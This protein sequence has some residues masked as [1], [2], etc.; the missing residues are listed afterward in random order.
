MLAESLK[1]GSL[2]M[3]MALSLVNVSHKQMSFKEDMMKRKLLA[4][5]T[6]IMMV[7][8]F[9]VMVLGDQFAPVIV[10]TP[11]S[12]EITPIL[13][14]QGGFVDLT[15]E[16]ILGPGNFTFVH[17][18]WM[19]A[20]ELAGPSVGDTAGDRFVS[21]ARFSADNLAIGTKVTVTYFIVVS[22]GTEVNEPYF[23][24]DGDAYIEIIEDRTVII[25]VE[26]KAAPAVAAAILKFNGVDARFGNGRSGGNFI[27]DVAHFMGPGTEFAG[28]PK[29][30]LVE[31]KEVSNPAYWEAVLDFLNA[32]PAM[33]VVLEM[34]EM[35]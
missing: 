21:T 32:H 24:A 4:L 27:A 1:C 33:K 15:A 30:I 26:A 19:N 3:V 22:R 10:I 9:S 6:T 14:E 34:P 7:L 18:G 2:G 12:S 13:V 29:S 31:G 16:T 11:D 8:S 17:G 23:E 25:E 35:D 28:E 20:E 5:F